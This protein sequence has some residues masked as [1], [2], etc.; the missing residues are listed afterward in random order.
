MTYG[1]NIIPIVWK[2]PRSNILRI[3]VLMSIRRSEKQRIIHGRRFAAESTS[4]SLRSRSRLLLMLTKARHLSVSSTT[5]RAA[6]QTSLWKT[7][8]IWRILGRKRQ[9][10]WLLQVFLFYFFV[11]LICL[12]VHRE[13][14]WYTLQ[15]WTA[16]IQDV[17][18]SAL[19]LDS[20]SSEWWTTCS[21]LRL[22]RS[23]YL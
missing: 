3:T 13:K 12:S 9:L 5:W 19:G 6:E 22:G 10:Y 15:R 4:N 21:A 11:V 17:L 8:R 2:M 23:A 1:R 18:P 7:T 14:V 16:R 20:R